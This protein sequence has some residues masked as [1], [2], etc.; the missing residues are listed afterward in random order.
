MIVLVHITDVTCINPK[1]CV[2]ENDSHVLDFL[3]ML[4]DEY[5]ERTRINNVSLLAFKNA[6]LARVKIIV[7]LNFKNWHDFFILCFLTRILAA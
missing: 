3:G 6:T 4:Y 1:F 7:H 2:V 5:T